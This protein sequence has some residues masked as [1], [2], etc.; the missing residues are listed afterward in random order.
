MSELKSPSL[1]NISVKQSG[2]DMKDG[3]RCWRERRFWRK[4]ALAFQKEGQE[5][6]REQSLGKGKEGGRGQRGKASGSLHTG[7]VC[8]RAGRRLLA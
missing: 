7:S 4:L 8:E 5:G 6:D 3:G 2:V 1:L